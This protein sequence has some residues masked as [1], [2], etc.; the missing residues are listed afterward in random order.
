MVFLGRPLATFVF[1]Q[2]IVD[3]GMLFQ[4]LRESAAA[5]CHYAAIQITSDR[6]CATS[7]SG[8]VLLRSGS[9]FG[10]SDNGR[11]GLSLGIP[12]FRCLFV[13]VRTHHVRLPERTCGTRAK[14][15][16]GGL[17]SESPKEMLSSLLDFHSFVFSAFCN[18]L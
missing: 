6:R 14:Q 11:S 2:R 17:H 4:L 8:G 5:P 18:L 3:L 10:F 7:L 13:T 1:F 12:V 15:L 9:C 16:W